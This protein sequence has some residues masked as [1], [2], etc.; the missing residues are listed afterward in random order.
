MRPG[1][2]CSHSSGFVLSFVGRG[3][4][5][6]HAA[7]FHR[8]MTA[9]AGTGLSRRQIG[10]SLAI[11]GLLMF[12]KFFY[13]ASL[14]SYYTFYLMDKFQHERPGARPA[15][16]LFAF[17]F[18]VAAGTV[19]GGPLGDRIGRKRVI[20]ISIL[21]VAPFTPAAAP[22]RPVLDLGDRSSSASSWRRFSAILV[23]ALDLVSPARSA[24]FR[25]LL[26]LRLRHGRVQG[27]PCCKI[28]PMPPASKPSS[29][30]RLSAP[31]GHGLTAFLPLSGRLGCVLKMLVSVHANSA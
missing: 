30:L 26:R 8:R 14:S 4:S 20:W 25:S 7:R 12:S 22:R 21:G 19:L 16:Y 11:L 2:R 15:I 28:G 9:H 13:M 1:S 18:A 23:Y 5:S 10:W 24:R 17:L 3:W 6:H 27:P 31:Y 29:G